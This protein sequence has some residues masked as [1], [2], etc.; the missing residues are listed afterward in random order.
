MIAIKSTIRIG[1]RRRLAG[2]CIFDIPAIERCV[3][4]NWEIAGKIPAATS[5]FVD[6]GMMA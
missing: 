4:V 3:S 1:N 6:F 5:Q 2:V